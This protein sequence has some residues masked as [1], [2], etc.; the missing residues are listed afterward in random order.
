V[1]KNKALKQKLR[2]PK[3]AAAVSNRKGPG[4]TDSTAA[5]TN[6]DRQFARRL[7]SNLRFLFAPAVVAALPFILSRRLWA[8]LWNGTRPLAWDGAGHYAIAQIYSQSIFPDTFGWTHAYFAGMPFPNFYPPV[9]YWLI[10]LL[11][12]SHLVSFSTAF[13]LVTFVPVLLVPASIWF[14][15][16]RVLQENH[17]AATAA[18]LGSVAL[19]LDERFLFPL[20]AGL[21][22]FSTFQIGLYTQPLGFVFMVAWYALYANSRQSPSRLALC[23]LL[24]A[25][26]VLTNFFSGATAAVFV[27]TT[28]IGDA[29]LYFRETDSERRS[30]ELRTLTAHLASPLLA[31]CLTLFWVVPVLGQYGYFVTRPYVIE[32]GQLM[33]PYLWLWYALAIAGSVLW[34]RRPTRA[35]LSYISACMVLA[36]AAT[37]A[38][39]LSPRWFPLQAPRFLITLNFLL[40]VPVGLLVVA[41]FRWL[42]W[43]LGEV[44]RKGQILSIG[45][46]RY[47]T[48]TALVLLAIFVLTSPAP[49]WGN[50]RSFFK[51]GEKSE[52]DELLSFASGHRDGRYLVEVI[53]PTLTP[54]YADSSFDARAL[55]SYLG[56]QGN[57][58]LVAVFHEAS[59]NALFMLPAVNALSSYPD[60]FGVSSALA[61]DLDFVA[62]PLSKHIERAKLLGVKYVVM[63]TPT[64]KE[65]LAKELLIGARHDF[66]WWSI[67][68]LK[69]EPPQRARVLPYS[70]ALVVSALKFKL[71]RSNE[72]SF[73]RLTEEQFADG[74]FDVL[75]AHS[76]DDKIDQLNNLERFGALVV[77]A[78]DYND[79]NRAYDVL[80]QFAQDRELILLSDDSQLFRRIQSSRADFPKLD[81]IERAN[82]GLGDQMEALQPAHHYRD[83]PIRRAWGAIR[84]AL[85][86]SKLPVAHGGD[87]IPTE[88]AQN[89]ISI[90]T[91]SVKRD[92]PVPV[93]IANTFHPNW[94]REDGET[95]YAATPFYTLTFAA[96]PVRLIYGRVWY[97]RLAIWVSVG[98]LAIVCL[99]LIWSSQS[100]NSQPLD[101]AAKSLRRR[102]RSVGLDRPVGS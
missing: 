88:L 47:T 15:G 82:L 14:L 89:K 42:A 18:A 69:D 19:L 13:K 27:A 94:R 95:I 68:E 59:P 11:Q 85:D 78:Y 66:G 30:L 92:S 8:D 50:A 61:D 21:D 29:V 10:A 64:M 17:L 100:A 16:R 3:P 71:R 80:K 32:A 44:D 41:G 96:G 38:T 45:R 4:P 90:G 12:G 36:I 31:A 54:A 63:R 101:Q 86:K 46:V 20:P 83:N 91:Q 52:I 70:P 57:E 97:E 23:G 81:I 33:T 28:V 39:V 79:Q 24:L 26:T 40:T 77:E 98:A 60:S 55:N 9:Y 1:A 87:Y 7:S 74:W 73:T 51:E 65:K 102:L 93:L 67:Y 99:W 72:W 49:R 76:P 48:A 43:L 62:Q 6:L 75:L 22:Y 34:L 56:A 53:N 84:L 58:T 37:F 2:H 25:L 35:A 5:A